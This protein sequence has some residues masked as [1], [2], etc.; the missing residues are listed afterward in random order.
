MKHFIFSFCLFLFS[1]IALPTFAADWT[2]VSRGDAQTLHAIM[3]D[4]SNIVAVGN[5]GS[6]FISSNNGATWSA[7][8]TNT[9]IRLFGETVMPNGDLF[10]VGE[11]GVGII[12]SD[13]GKTWSQI[14]LGVTGNMHSISSKKDSG[15]IVGE[16][17]IFLTRN[18]STNNWSSSSL[19]VTDDFFGTQDMGDGT[20]WV[21]GKNGDIFHLF[22]SGTSYYKVVLTTKETFRAVKFTD[23][24]NGWIVG[25]QGTV[26]HT[27][28]GGTTWNP[29][30]IVGVTTQLLYAIDVSGDR[31]VIAGDKVL[32]TSDDAGKT[33]KVKSFADTLDTF[34]G[35][36]IATDGSAFAVGSDY[37]IASLIYK[38]SSVQSQVVPPV[39]EPTIAEGTAVQSSLIKL[40]CSANADVNDPCK[41]VYFY[42]TDGKRHA[43]TNDKVYFS[44]FTDFSTVKIVSANFLASLTLGK[45]VT[46]R[47]GVKMVKFQT[48]MQVYAV[49]KGGVL[50]AIATES[51]AAALYG[52]DWNKKIDDISDVF[53]GDYKFGEP[54]VTA[55]DYDPAQARIL[56][57]SISDN[58]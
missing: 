35:A 52:S 11:S 22:L 21:V 7:Q 57:G 46:Y 14:N 6:T 15:Y 42:A 24:H 49:A 8:N 25:T 47:P 10:A 56:V 44:W 53:F 41:A 16:G 45:N 36:L 29:V 43:F 38:S 20:G 12:S 13:H 39:T 5:K 51:V 40:A 33:W 48:S 55:S 26:L 27:T 18:G 31:M 30:S 2:L 1:A 9:S 28:D 19:G 23:V 54:I 58:F 50:R 3:L 17:G 32:I 37:D 34:Y 4:G